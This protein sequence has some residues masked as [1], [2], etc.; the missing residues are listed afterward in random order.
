[1]L[2]TATVKDLTA[3]LAPGTRR[4]Y[5]TLRPLT[6][7]ALNTLA[8]NP[9]A[10]K[11]VKRVGRG[12]S[13][14]KGKTC[15]RGQKGQKARAGNGKPRLNFEG[16]QT[17]LSKKYPKRGF[18]N[19]H[20]KEYTVLNLD[21]LQQWIDMGRLDACRKITMKE[22]NDSGCVKVKADGVQLLAG[23]VEQLRTPVDLEVSRASTQAIAAIEAV[24][25]RISCVYH[26]ALGLRALLH[27]EKFLKLPKQALPTKKRDVEWY[28]DAKHRG[29]LA[30]LPEKM[31]IPSTTTEVA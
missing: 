22:L 24:G 20:G 1:M 15:G 3:R 14:G 6:R 8:D 16:G 27:P 17:P 31:A 9:G 25:G 10:V 4:C 11:R 28:S 21:K 7:I 19:I 26:N 30:N 29:Y 2:L 13:S 5:A 18:T 12:S 23:G